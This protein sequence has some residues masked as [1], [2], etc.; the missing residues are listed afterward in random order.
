ME[1]RRCFRERRGDGL[2]QQRGSRSDLLQ[3]GFGLGRDDDVGQRRGAAARKRE[4]GKA[5]RKIERPT[6]MMNEKVSE[7][8]DRKGYPLEMIGRWRSRSVA[9]LELN[10]AAARLEL[11][12][13]FL[14]FF[15]WY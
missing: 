5:D 10:R 1:S 12:F 3:I 6:E 14:F 11:G 7:G 4:Q 8:T 9:R 2:E 15:C 13:F